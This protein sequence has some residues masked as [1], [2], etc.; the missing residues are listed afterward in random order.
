MRQRSHRILMPV[1][2]RRSKLASSPPCSRVA[3]N[4][5]HHELVHKQPSRPSLDHQLRMRFSTVLFSVASLLALA[6]ASPVESRAC[7]GVSTWLPSR[8]WYSNLSDW[9]EEDTTILTLYA[10]PDPTPCPPTPQQVTFT[11][12]VGRQDSSPTS[13]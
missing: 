2:L 10:I 7:P 12:Y 1:D 4:A 9:N 5:I 8:T 3:R 6:A 13:V 11:V